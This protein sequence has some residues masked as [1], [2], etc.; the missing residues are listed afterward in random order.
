MI[1][2]FSRGINTV[3]VQRLSYFYNIDKINVF[4]ALAAKFVFCGERLS[5]SWKLVFMH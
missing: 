3:Q 2:C 4:C 1:H 5:G